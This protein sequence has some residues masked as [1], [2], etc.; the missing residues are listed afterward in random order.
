[1]HEKR[2]DLFTVL[3][4]L[5]VLLSFAAADIVLKTGEGA[6]EGNRPYFSLTAFAEGRYRDEYGQYAQ[7]TVV[8]KEKWVSLL[9]RLELMMGRR[10]L[11]GVYL[12]KDGYLFEADEPDVREEELEEKLRLL[13]QLTDVWDARVML[14]P[15]KDNLLAKK[16]PESA[17]YYDETEVCERVAA[18]VGAERYVDVYSALASHAD[19]EI[20]FRTDEHWT[21]LGAFYSYNAWAEAAGKPKFPYERSDARTAM[22]DCIGELGARIT[23][24]WGK[25]SVVYFPETERRLLSVTYDFLTDSDTMYHEQWPKEGNPY[26][27]F[28]D[29]GHVFTRITSNR[30]NGRTLFVLKDSYADCFLPFLL[31]H[32]ETIYVLEPDGYGDALEPFMRRFGSPKTMEVLVLYNT[33]SFMETFDYQE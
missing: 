6:E 5:F 9:E 13:G 33:R 3:V 14:I 25:D 15:S 7:S 27:F 1:M 2:N 18:R 12:G 28:M 22:E 32:Y 11:K 31:A 16:L 30:K 24:P 26:G 21:A 29:N 8:G 19:E 10:E 4:I 17:P 23:L 20:Y